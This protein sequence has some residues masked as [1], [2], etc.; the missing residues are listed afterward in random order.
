MNEIILE[1]QNLL[2]TTLGSTYKKYYFWEIKVPNQ[3]YLPFLEIIPITS[4]LSNRGTGGMMNNEFQ[5]QI[6]LKNT[7]KKYLKQDTNVETLEHV[8]DL[9][10]KW[11]SEPMET[12]TPI[13]S[14][15][16][17]IIIYSFQMRT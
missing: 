10:K 3:A 8:Q 12:L 7:L 15:E 5:V 13:V 2:R 9:V 14:Y 1:I 11:K 4:R 17:F 6:N 16:S